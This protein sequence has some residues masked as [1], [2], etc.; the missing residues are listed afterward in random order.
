MGKITFY[1]E[2]KFQGRCYNC[3]SD[4]AD[5]HSYFTRCSSIRVESGVWVIYERPNYKGF[6][7][8]LCPGEYAD[9]QQWMA[10]SDSVKSCRAIKNVRV[11]SFE[12]SHSDICPNLKHLD[13]LQGFEAIP[14]S[15]SK[16]N[17]I[18]SQQ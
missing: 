2:K 4:C 13:M 15:L 16:G 18:Y 10:F 8:I 6:Q 5:L 14:S 3:S 11:D 7:Y 1:E 9:N 12:L 17:V